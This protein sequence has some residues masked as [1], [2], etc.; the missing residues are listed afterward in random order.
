MAERLKGGT[1]RRRVDNTVRNLLLAEHRKRSGPGSRW[2][3]PGSPASDYETAL[4]SGA[5]VLVDSSGLM[6]ALMHANLPSD[7]YAYGGTHWGK[8]F[9][10]DVDGTLTEWTAADAAEPDEMEA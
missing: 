1:G 8:Q 7:D 2:Y 5:A 6:C 9:L 3:R 4:V 10:L